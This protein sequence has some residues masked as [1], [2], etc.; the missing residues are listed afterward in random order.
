MGFAIADQMAALGA[1]VILIAG[2][3]TQKTH[4]AIKRVDVTSAAEMLAACQ[5]YFADAR[6]CI[7][8]AAVAD[9][10]PIAVA[11]QKNKKEG[12]RFKHRTKKNDGYFKNPWR[13]K[14]QRPAIS[15]FCPGNKRRRAER[16]GEATKK[17][18]GL[19]CA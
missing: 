5:L 16:H 7:M 8:S 6:I 12:S 3:T 1:D 19:Y 4:H 13:S 2:P 15:R 9:Y 17:E 11:A 10:T 14:T 18:P